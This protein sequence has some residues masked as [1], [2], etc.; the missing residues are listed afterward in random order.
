MKAIHNILFAL[1]VSSATVALAAPT[2][3]IPQEQVAVAS[4]VLAA[5]GLDAA[6]SLRTTDFVN[7]SGR[8]QVTAYI[9]YARG[10]TGAAT[11]V[12]LTCSAGRLRSKLAP[13]PIL[14]NTLTAGTREMLTHVWTQDVSA[15]VVIR[16]IVTP[17]ND[18]WMQCIVDS[19]GVVTGDDVVTVYIRKGAL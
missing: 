2:T 9:E 1:A 7:V 3:P 16:V 11:A 15:T 6:E 12:T 10:A 4:P 19:A 17:L 8:T 13:L 14:V 5:V 18:A